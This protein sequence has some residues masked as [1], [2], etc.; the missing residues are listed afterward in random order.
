MAAHALREAPLECCG[1][2]TGTGQKIDGIVRAVNQ[3]RSQTAFSVS[4]SD[5]FDFFRGL[6]RSGR[7]FLGIYHSHPSGVAVPSDRDVRESHYPDVSY[8]IISL[9]HSPPDIRCYRWGRMG[10]EEANFEV[11]ARAEYSPR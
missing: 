8:W 1:F 7:R 3:E 6:R 11:A 5:L 9:L 4:P 2:L 10:F